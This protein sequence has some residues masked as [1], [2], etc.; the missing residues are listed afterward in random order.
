MGKNQGCVGQFGGFA[1]R[2]DQPVEQREKVDL[3]HVIVDLDR[4]MDIRHGA[5]PR[6]HRAQGVACLIGSGSARHHQF[7]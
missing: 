6:F 2:L 3:R 1:G 4:G 5:H 7:A